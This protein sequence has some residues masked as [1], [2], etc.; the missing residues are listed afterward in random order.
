MMRILLPTDLS[1]DSYSTAGTVVQLLG[2]DRMHYVLVHTY[3]TGD[4]DD[5]LHPSLL[6]EVKKEAEQRMQALEK[7]L[8]ARFRG[9]D[10]RHV[11]DQGPL[12]VVVD[13]EVRKSGADLVAVHARQ[14]VRP[15]LIAHATSLMRSSSVPVLELPIGA[16]DLKI[17]KIL[18]AD[19]GLPI[20]RSALGV[21]ATLAAHARAEIIVAHVATGRPMGE[22]TDHR[23]LFE[24]TFKGSAVR[25][26]VVEHDD[27]IEGL[28]QA[29]DR[30]QADL[31][32]VL[33][34]HGS[35]M[36]DLFHRSTAHG[37]EKAWQLPLLVLEQ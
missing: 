6:V 17:R 31:V 19:D 5:P 8:L 11:I 7:R 12:Y 25:D 1:E 16:K 22:R 34:R 3:Y 27:V 36:H 4:L 9:L 15:L 33:H 13:K 14:P 18:F 35:V 28:L 32:A 20:E 30:E 2:T 26:V 21:L 29:A 23:P 24:A 37:L 10:V